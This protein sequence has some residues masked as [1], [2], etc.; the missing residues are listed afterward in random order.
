V[1][2]KHERVKVGC[3]VAEADAAL[4]VVIGVL[5]LVQLHS[6]LYHVRASQSLGHGALPFGVVAHPPYH[7]ALTTILV[8]RLED[9]ALAVL[10]DV[11]DEVNLAVVD[12][13]Q[14]FLNLAR[15][16]DMTPDSVQLPRAEE[17]RV[18]VIMQEAKAHLH[19]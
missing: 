15:P 11:G 1:G 9:E 17:V 14:T 7:H 4:R 19:V 12:G 2:T 10:Q 18:Y 5:L 3:E 16:G 8:V 6:A 13:G